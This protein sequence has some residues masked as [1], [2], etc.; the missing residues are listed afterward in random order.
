MK[1]SFRF[2]EKFLHKNKKNYALIDSEL[3]L[4]WQTCPLTSTSLCVTGLGML[5]SKFPSAAG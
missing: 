4:K 3:A 2:L 1:N 5:V